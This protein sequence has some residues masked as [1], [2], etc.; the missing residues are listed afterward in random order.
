[1]WSAFSGNGLFVFSDPAGAK[2][3]L[4]LNEI[5]AK[6]NVEGERVLLSNRNYPFYKQFSSKVELIDDGVAE[7]VSKKIEKPSWIFA[8]TS[9]LDSSKGF[10]LIFLKNIKTTSYAIIDHWT[11]FK[12]RFE[13]NGGLV[14]PDTIFVL[15]NRAEALAIAD[16]LP[17][18]RIKIT[19][20]PY[21]LYLK[22]YPGPTIDKTAFCKKLD[23]PEGKK[24]VLYAPDPVSL[25]S[26]SHKN[27]L[28]VLEELLEL[29]KGHHTLL[30]KLHPLQPSEKISALIEKKNN[31]RIISDDEL[32][33]VD[34]FSNVD[35]IVGFY[36]NYLLEAATVSRN[37]ISYKLDSGAEE[38]VRH[39]LKCT[40]VSNKNELNLALKQIS[41]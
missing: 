19:E 32:M 7:E 10:E 23:I 35:C 40:V 38:H 17:K 33:P 12:L 21:L 34:V 13:L 31:V 9:H 20:N 1:M 25:R 18:E 41:G 6:E 22:K 28:T 14:L 15:D 26:R 27:E 37:I 11:D 29:V 3:C 24:I 16:G 30:L 4:A 39:V 36:S 8:G 2:A 5:L